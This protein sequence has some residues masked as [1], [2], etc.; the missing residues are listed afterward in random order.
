VSAVVPDDEL[1]T[2]AQSYLDAML[3][4][5]PMGLRLTKDALNL[6]I[7]APSLEAAMAIE[8]RQQALVALTSDAREAQ[9]AFFEKRAPEFR[10][11]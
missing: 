7:D 10:D 11:R 9:R 6:N 5:S 8:D 4:T 3:R 1:E 2:A